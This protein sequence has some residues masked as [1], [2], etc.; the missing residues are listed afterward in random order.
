VKVPDSAVQIDGDTLHI[1]LENIPEVD[2][3]AFPPTSWNGI[4]PIPLVPMH[5]SFDITYSKSG[6]ARRIRPASEDPLSP[7]NW[8]GEMWDATNSGTFTAT[9]DDNSFSV[10]GSFNSSGNF[11]EMG[12]ERNGVFVEE[13]DSPAKQDAQIP[14]PAPDARATPP[15]K[16]ILLKGRIPV[17]ISN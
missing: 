13:G 1:H 2:A 3:F 11:G 14:P 4:S 9:Y 8:A 6:K 10:T 12:T 7:L 15:A 17:K 5:V 16:S